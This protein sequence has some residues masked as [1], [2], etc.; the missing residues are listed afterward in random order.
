M[1][2][3]NIHV[4]NMMLNIEHV[5]FNIDGNYVKLPTNHT[6]INAYIVAR[7][8]YSHIL[9][10]FVTTIIIRISANKIGSQ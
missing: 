6:N 8:T 7:R 5:M 1:H 3:T 9:Q 2:I 4:H 10:A